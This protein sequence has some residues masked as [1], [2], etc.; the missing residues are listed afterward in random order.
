MLTACNVCEN[1]F[2]LLELL[3]KRFYINMNTKSIF[4]A[5]VELLHFKAYLGK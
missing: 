2:C 3:Q 4:I 5:N 1:C